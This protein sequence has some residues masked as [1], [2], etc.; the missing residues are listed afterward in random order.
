MSETAVRVQGL[1]KA[2]KTYPHPSDLFR[3]IL[4]RRRRH[5]E[6]WA[7]REVS[8]SI[9]RG[10]V[11]GLI[12]RN[13]AGKSTLLKIITGTLDA[14]SGTVEVDGKVSALLELGTGF[15]PEYTGR[16]NIYTGGL[17]LGMERREIDRKLSSIIEFSELAGVIDQPLKTFSTG[18][19]ARLAFAVAI[20][21][22]PDIFVI[23]EALSVGDVLFQEKCFRRIR[24]IASSG[25]TVIFVT[26]SYPLIYEL[27][28]RGLLLH[29]GVLLTDDGPRKVGHAYERLIAEE[30]A[31]R[32]VDVSTG[33]QAGG[34]ATTEARVLEAT[35]LNEEGVEVGTL[36]HPRT[37][38]VRIRCACYED[39]PALSVGYFI[40]KPTGQVLY[41][42]GSMY[43]RKEL[44]AKAGELLDVRFSLPCRLG[45]GQYL[46]SAAVS[47]ANGTSDYRVAHIL[48]ESR[49]FT[50]VS[51]GLF[52]GDIDLQSELLSVTTAPS[53]EAEMEEKAVPSRH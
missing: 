20:S 6:H 38:S 3:E 15:S 7:L 37:Y 23:D 21:V 16:E 31:Q 41:R 8:F 49:A 53:A 14:T 39:I 46:L 48:R 34:E 28:D 43:M 42:V 5:G 12:G 44:R 4:T 2:Y 50:V 32:R 24:D 29:E 11:V 1:S 10:Q 47:I 13:G 19:Q 40:Q 25:A 22:E 30:R 36:F 35:L 26:H 52:G 27:C 51:D 45:S 17:C 33:L 18:M 9:P